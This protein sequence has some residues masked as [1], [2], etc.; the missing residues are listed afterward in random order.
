VI[1]LTSFRRAAENEEKQ[2]ANFP[3]STL[4]IWS[5]AVY[6]PHWLP[7]RPKAE[8]MD[9]REDGHSWIRPREFM[10]RNL[11]LDGYFQALQELYESRLDQIW[12]WADAARLLE[13]VVTWV[14]CWCP[15]D[16]AAK[17]QLAEYGTF[18]CHLAAV[19]RMLNQLGFKIQYDQD[20]TRMV[21]PTLTS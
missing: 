13:G 14:C 18:V 15:Y 6:Q 21:Q 19:G 1:L 7:Q 2:R 8:W 20:R 17:R 16:Q 5:G 9:I 10:D 12:K 4:N 11:P 3:H